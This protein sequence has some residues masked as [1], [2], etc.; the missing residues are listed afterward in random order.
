MLKTS[1]LLLHAGP[2]GAYYFQF[3]DIHDDIKRDMIAVL[4]L[5]EMLLRKSS[6]AGDRAILRR[7][8]PMVFTRL[9]LALPMYTQTMVVHYLV[10]HAVEHLEETG[11]FPVSNMLD[12]ER[13]QTVLKALAKSKK[14]TMASIVNNYTLLQSALNSRLAKQGGWDWAVCPC[15]LNL[16]SLAY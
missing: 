1:E 8:L 2:V 16:V 4:R 9:E 11:P 15:I 6:T 7:D 10:Y 13:F 12:M 14:N 3:L 5:L